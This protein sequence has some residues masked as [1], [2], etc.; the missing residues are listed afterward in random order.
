MD[1]QQEQRRLSQQLQLQQVTFLSLSLSLSLSLAFTHI[2]SLVADSATTATATA[3]SDAV[4]STAEGHG[5]AM[6]RRGNQTL[7]A[8]ECRHSHQKRDSLLMGKYGHTALVHGSDPAD[9][10]RYYREPVKRV[11]ISEHEIGRAHV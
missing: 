10:S 8:R 6:L 1:P 4:D 5:G 3:A 2:I 9:P 11:A 7:A